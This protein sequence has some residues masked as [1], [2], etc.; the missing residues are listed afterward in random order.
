MSYLVISVFITSPPFPSYNHSW[1]WARLRYWRVLK[2]RCAVFWSRI[3]V[4]INLNILWR[5]LYT[6]DGKLRRETGLWWIGISSSL[7]AFGI[8]MM[9]ACFQVL[10]K[11]S[12]RVQPMNIWHSL[13]MICEPQYLRARFRMLS[14]SGVLCLSSFRILL[15]SLPGEKK[16]YFW[17]SNLSW[18]SMV[19]VIVVWN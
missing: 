10:G 17:Y 9:L 13:V 5:L 3:I 18:S 19:S 1:L 11:Y 7:Q 8:V 4:L 16:V 15:Q 12:K 6:F 14:R 2:M